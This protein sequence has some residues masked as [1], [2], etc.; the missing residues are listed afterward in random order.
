MNSVLM[1]DCRRAEILSWCWR[2]CHFFHAGNISSVGW[3][4]FG[5]FHKWSNEILKCHETVLNGRIWVKILDAFGSWTAEQRLSSSHCCLSLFYWASVW[6]PLSADICSSL[7]GQWFITCFS[8][9]RYSNQIILFMEN[10]PIYM[11]IK[12]NSSLIRYFHNFMGKKI[13]IFLHIHKCDVML[14]LQFNI[15]QFGWLFEWKCNFSIICK[16]ISFYPIV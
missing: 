3:T 12:I 15:V 14:N 10:W 1:D 6:P 4:W 8:L 7:S 16:H 9:Q 5:H 2:A 11:D 13:H